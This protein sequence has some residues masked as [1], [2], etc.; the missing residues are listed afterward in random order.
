M[1]A[2]KSISLLHSNV[3]SINKN[4]N[5]LLAFIAKQG[6]AFEIVAT[7]E[8]WLRRHENIIIPG[9]VTVSQPRESRYRGGGVALF[10]TDSL[11]YTILSSVS[12]C[13]PELEALFLK[14]ECGLIVGVV[15]RPPSSGLAVFFDKLEIILSSLTRCNTNRVLIVGD[16][17]IDTISANTIDYTCL[18]RSYNFRNLINSPTRITTFSATSIDHALTNIDAGVSAGLYQTPISDHLPIFVKANISPIIKVNK[19]GHITRINYESFRN[20]LLLIS[21]DL[22]YH[23]DVNIEF[24]NLINTL[25]E[26]I[27]CSSRNEV[28]SQRYKPICPWMTE[29]ILNILRKKDYWYHKWLHHKGNE[30]YLYQFKCARNKSVSL[31]RARKKEY[32]TRRIQGAA[33]NS[34]KMWEVVNEITRNSRKCSTLPSKL[35]KNT[36]DEF[37]TF[38][39]SVGP[40]LA[41]KLPDASKQS[42][43]PS[44]VV[45]SFALHEVELNEVLSVVTALATNKASGLDGIPAKLIKENIDILGPIL[46]RLFNHSLHKCT[47]PSSLKIARVTPVFKDGDSS[48]PSSYRPISVLSVINNIFEKILCKRVHHFLEKYNIICPQQHGFRPKHS[49]S[50]AVITLTQAINSALHNNRLAVVIFLDIKKAFDTVNHEIM[51]NKL[52]T[53]GF[54][55]RVLDFFSSYFTNRQQVVSMNNLT[56]SVQ[57]LHTG[58]PQGSTLGPL[59]FSLYVNDLPQIL[60]SAN[61]VMYADDTAIIVTANHAAELESIANIELEKIS[62][63][64]LTNKLTVNTKKTKYVLFQS[65]NKSL[66]TIDIKL[67]ISQTQ[68]EPTDHFTY[69]GVTLD[70]HLHWQHQIDSIC[71]KIA[72][73]CYA[74]LQLREYFDAS[75]LRVLYLTLV[76]THLTYCIESW[77]W[78]Y[79]TYLEPIRRSQKRALRIIF[80]SDYSQPSKTL[81]TKPRVLPFDLLREKK[82]AECIHNIV[83]NN[84]PFDVSIFNIP[85]RATRNQTYGNFN[86]AVKRNVYGERMLEFTG[87]KIWNNLP[88]DLK[89]ANNF[90]VAIKSHYLKINDTL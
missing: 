25:V 89:F 69:L 45:N 10:V 53:Y 23:E 58:V 39:T 59:L 86:L 44:P 90:S 57:Y 5:S 65:R 50:S 18:L 29:E 79:N 63:W 20:K 46:C 47:Y 13:S 36:V 54:R 73:G 49:T 55:E 83:R 2:R 37:N 15:Y 88:Y 31:M 19:P 3:R 38:F 48:D 85:S 64:Y 21:T 34:K 35:T 30:Y 28:S 40:D 26:L 33:G 70:K 41:A 11:Q 8:T 17:N 4:L 7:T 66:D 75:V 42:D 24:S 78:T 82:T 76:H 72:S 14:L 56:S 9:Y 6:E 52:R 80:F 87:T 74:L 84:L 77:G 27:K 68:L 51:L 12:C 67:T 71:A 1:A 16:M 32:F 60:T 62:N 81:F 61:A 22:I 43:P